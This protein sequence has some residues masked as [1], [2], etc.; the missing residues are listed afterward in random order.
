MASEQEWTEPVSSATEQKPAVMPESVQPFQQPQLQPQEPQNVGEGF[1]GN[2]PLQQDKPQP[3]EQQPQQPQEPQPP[4]QPKEPQGPAATVISA[5]MV[6]TGEVKSTGN[7]EILGMIK[8]PVITTGNMTIEGKILGNIE[9]NDIVLKGCAIQG[10]INATGNVNMDQ[11]SVVIGDLRAANLEVNGKIKGNLEIQERIDLNKEAV[12][13]GNA[14]SRY[15]S[16]SQG[17]K[18]NGNV[19]VTA[20]RSTEEDIFDIQF[21]I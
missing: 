19:S 12:V 20:D 13:D 4:L 6:I 17:A 21:D 11:N 18:L 8:G 16:M 5:S 10:N 9:G 2:W 7:L 1:L 14:S 3:T 15:V